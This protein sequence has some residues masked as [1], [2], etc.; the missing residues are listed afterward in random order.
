[1]KWDLFELIGNKDGYL[2]RSAVEQNIYWFSVP[3]QGFPSHSL[4]DP[5]AQIYM[6]I[7]QSWL[8]H[9]TNSIPSNSQKKKV[10]S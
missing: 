3:Q 9:R 1:M 2:C 8:Q 6:N 7:K 5:P 4:M 10:Q